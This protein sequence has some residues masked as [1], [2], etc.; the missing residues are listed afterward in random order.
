M[1]SPLRGCFGGSLAAVHAGT[2]VHRRP[3]DVCICRCESSC[4]PLCQR[5]Q[6][7]YSTD[8]ISHIYNHYYTSLLMT[9]DLERCTRKQVTCKFNIKLKHI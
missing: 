8:S 5:S 2:L 1:W 3:T 9:V 6:A 4:V 7:D